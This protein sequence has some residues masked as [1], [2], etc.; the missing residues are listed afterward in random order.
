ML[1]SDFLLLF[2][3]NQTKFYIFSIGAL[4]DLNEII[5]VWRF[6]E[7]DWLGEIFSQKTIVTV[8]ILDKLISGSWIVHHTECNGLFI[9]LYLSWLVQGGYI[10]FSVRL[11]WHRRFHESI[12][13]LVLNLFMGDISFDL[14]LLLILA[15]VLFFILIYFLKIITGTFLD[16]LSI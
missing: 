11:N 13:E 10:V 15:F 3:R 7:W 4:N 9:E 1:C 14:Q 2:F 6:L 16:L 12:C 8:Y 5:L